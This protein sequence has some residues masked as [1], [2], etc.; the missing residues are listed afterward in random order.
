MS[1]GLNNFTESL[2]KRLNGPMLEWEWTVYDDGE[3]YATLKAEM[4]PEL[5]LIHPYIYHCVPR[6]YKHYKGWFLNKM[7]VFRETF[8]YLSIHACTENEKMVKMLFSNEMKAVGSVEGS[9]VYR[10]DF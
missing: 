10:Y 2:T 3:I 6:T 8:S 7:N 1:D 9:V 5:V 4:L